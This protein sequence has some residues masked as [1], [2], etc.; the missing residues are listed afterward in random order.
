MACGISGGLAAFEEGF[1]LLILAAKLKQK[2]RK[3]TPPKRDFR[4]EELARR[5][6]RLKTR[7]NQNF[8]RFGVGRGRKVEEGSGV[9]RGLEVGCVYRG[10]WPGT[11]KNTGGVEED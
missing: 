2:N 8:R 3:N 5:T 6:R 7:I 1:P 4:E 10:H 9:G 11:H